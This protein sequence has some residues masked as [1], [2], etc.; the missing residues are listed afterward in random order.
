MNDRRRNLLSSGLALLCLAVIASAVVGLSL[1]I[2]VAWTI[3]A[4]VVGFVVVARFLSGSMG[5]GILALGLGAGMAIG[6]VLA[7]IVAIGRAV[8]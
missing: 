4:A 8:L 7:V 6:V 5:G 2:G 3:I 1:W